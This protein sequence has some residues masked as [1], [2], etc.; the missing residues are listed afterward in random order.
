MAKVVPFTKNREVIYD[1]LKRARRYHC[2]CTSQHQID[3]TDLLA[4]L[5]HYRDIGQPVS[6][7]ACL[8]RATSLL[9]K[10]YP[11]LNHHLFH[12][13]VRKYEVDFEQICC[14]VIMLRKHERELILLPVLIDNSDQLSVQEIDKVLTYHKT[15]PLD[16]LPAVQGMQKMKKLPRVALK[17]FSYMARSNH[18]FY[19]KFFGTYGYSSLLM[20]RED[21]VKLGDNGMA[22][23]SAS[24]T[25]TGFI[26]SSVADRAV[27][28]EGKVVARKM[29]DIVVLMDH[30]LVDG[31]DVFMATQYLTKL[32][33]QPARLGLDVPDAVLAASAT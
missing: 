32:L 21:G 10:R 12:G 19:R 11:R 27:V 25:C 6:I 16:Q 2:T 15:T 3:V 33:T 26:P 23:M 29:L 14:N 9:L 22:A 7:N 20:D 4:T 1:L 13:V 31:H 8:I 30:Y 24:N 5:D 18:R 28:I 17:A